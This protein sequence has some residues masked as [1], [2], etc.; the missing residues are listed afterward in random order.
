[1]E[2]MADGSLLSP[3]EGRPS[4]LWLPVAAVAAVLSLVVLFLPTVG[5]MGAVAAGS[6]TALLSIAAL[7]RTRSGTRAAR[8]SL[9][10]LCVGLMVMGVGA[11]LG[12]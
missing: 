11:A 5:A 12:S 6:V 4:P 3:H 9:V 10:V 8:S 7:Q 2:H 1:M